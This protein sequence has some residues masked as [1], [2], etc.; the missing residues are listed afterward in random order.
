[1]TAECAIVQPK[2]E[3]FLKAVRKG[4]SVQ[5]AAQKAKIHRNTV[6]LWRKQ[7]EEFAAAWDEAKE[8]RADW[9]EDRLRDQAEAG[10]VTAIIVG[11]KMRGRFKETQQVDL[12]APAHWRFTIGRGYDE[13]DARY[14]GPVVVNGVANEL[15]PAIRAE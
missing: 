14:Q 2:K 6:Y 4:S 8:S 13:A 15:P 7:D 10:N 1:M 9:Y 11:L 5:F 12:N 3:I